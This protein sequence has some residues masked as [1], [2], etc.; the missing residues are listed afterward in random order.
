MNIL[1]PPEE[2]RNSSVHVDRLTAIIIRI[3]N[4][5]RHVGTKSHLVSFE[6]TE[7]NILAIVTFTERTLYEERNWFLRGSTVL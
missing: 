4:E 5:R 1:I 2:L 7:P 3:V 6:L